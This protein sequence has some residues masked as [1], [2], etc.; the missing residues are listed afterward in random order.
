MRFYTYNVGAQLVRELDIAGA[1]RQ[2][3]HDGGDIIHLELLT[4][5][6]LMVHLIESAIP[7]YEIRGILKNNKDRN[8]HTLFILWGTMLLPSNG[9]IVY[10]ED[11]QEALLQIYGDKIYAY[12]IHQQRLYVYPIYFERLGVNGKAKIRYGTRIDVGTLTPHEVEVRMHGLEGTWRIAA[13]DGDPDYYHRQQARNLGT[14]NPQQIAAYYALLQVA[15]NAPMDEVK[16][17][18]RGLA[19]KYHP[20]MN[21]HDPEATRR[22]QNLNQAYNAILK[23]RESQDNKSA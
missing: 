21:A 2:I 13:F 16:S 15:P 22:M 9:R 19:R 3:L 4:G 23:D 11:W 5:D 20:D 8:D 1:V 7:L 6:L 12:D 17:A 10:I 18:Y 14:I